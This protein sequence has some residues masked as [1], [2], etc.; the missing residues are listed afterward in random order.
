MRVET[1][2]L[3][4][5]EFTQGDLDATQHLHGKGDA[6]RYQGF[7]LSDGDKLRASIR[8]AMA[9]ALEEPRRVYEL[10]VVLKEGGQ[11]IGRCGVTKA[12]LEPKEGVMWFVSDPRFW[13]QGF[14]TEAADALFRFCFEELKLH[15]VTGECDPK[16]AGSTHLME[17]LGMRKEAHLVE[18]AWIGGAW[19]D[20]AVY[21]LLEREWNGRKR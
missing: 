19:K 17:K 2:R 14:I 4:L 18:N 15:R 6:Q 1:K 10:A 13:N 21:A 9:H 16:N 12:L 5:R 8:L 7:D 11:L 20:T 3:V